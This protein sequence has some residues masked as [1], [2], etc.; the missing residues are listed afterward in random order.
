[1]AAIQNQGLMVNDVNEPAPENIP[2]TD[3]T[4][5]NLAQLK[6]GQRRRWDGI[7]CRHV[8][9]ASDAK[10]S[11]KEGWLPTV[12][13]FLEIFLMCLPLTFIVLTILTSTTATL[14]SRKVAPLEKT[15]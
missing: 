15:P 1:M 7:D 9:G 12:K 2:C 4:V 10:P 11:F 13:T 6:E 8:S 3:A 5:P 14:A